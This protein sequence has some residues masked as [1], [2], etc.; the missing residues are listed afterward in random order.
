MRSKI[1]QLARI[2]GADP[3]ELAEMATFDSVAAGICV[4]PGCDYTTNVEPDSDSG[5][6]ENCGTNT[7]T[8]ILMLMGII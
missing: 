2:E 7:V 6:C 1:A 8:S 5:W 3:M 4:N